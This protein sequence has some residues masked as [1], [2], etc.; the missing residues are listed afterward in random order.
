MVGFG[1]SDIMKRLSIVCL[2]LVAFALP[3]AGQPKFGV[4]ATA[5]P[6]V[7][8]AKFKSYVWQSGWDANDKTVHAAITG[9]VDKEL[10]A[11]GFERKASG[12]SDVIVKYASLRR[13]D[14]QPSTKATGAEAARS[15]IDVGSLLLLLLEPG[16]G[17]E[18][19]R[20]R[21]DKPIEIDMTKM[22][23]TVTG[24]VAELFTQYPTRLPKKK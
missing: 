15:Q 4:T 19:W 18:L 5:A 3:A 2:A 6:G 23:A 16:T 21:I 1:G 17:K 12:P 20:A 22:D 8:F 10:K 24:A 11:L 7:D 14:V 9:A 13:I